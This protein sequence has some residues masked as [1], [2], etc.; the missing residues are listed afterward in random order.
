MIDTHAHLTEEVLYQELDKIISNALTN[1]VSKIISVGMTNA[2][3]LK[4]ILI[5][6]KY[7]NVY[8]TVGIHPNAATTERLDLVLLKDL[9]K[10][11]K[12]IGIGEIGIDLYRSKDSLEIQKKYFIEQIKLAIEVNLPIIVHSRNSA[13]VIYE[14][15]KDFQGLKGVMH[16]YSEHLELVSKFINLGFYIGVGGIITFKNAHE[17]REIVKKVPLDKLLI[18]TDA[19]YLAPAPYRGKRN[20][21]AYVKETLIK[22]AEI[23]NVSEKEL[24]NI[25]R[26]NTYRLFLKM[27]PKR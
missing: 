24:I 1:G 19:P 2:D 18:E 20:E 26:E 11:K 15:V 17:V 23:K 3:N 14:I 9:T 25:T 16:C 12:V 27:R 8:T 21:P 10:N 13:S 22:L 4:S 7:E 6:K 5:S